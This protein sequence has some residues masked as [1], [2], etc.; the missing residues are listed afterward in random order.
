[1]VCCLFIVP[2]SFLLLAEDRLSVYNVDSV[3]SSFLDILNVE[4]GVWETVAFPDDRNSPT[5]R[6]GKTTTSKPNASTS[7]RR[8]GSILG[9]V[10][11]GCFKKSEGSE[12]VDCIT[13]VLRFV[14]DHRTCWHGY[15][16]G[17][18]PV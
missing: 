12:F 3:L 9:N 18:T 2:L 17:I 15:I 11:T 6:A 16:C 4:W 13:D 5:A 14:E 10:Y 8:L 1:M 7:S